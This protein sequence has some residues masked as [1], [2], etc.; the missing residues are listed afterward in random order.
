MVSD[1]LMGADSNNQWHI[2]IVLAGIVL[3]NRWRGDV[4]ELE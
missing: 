1:D 4:I 2:I 3:Y